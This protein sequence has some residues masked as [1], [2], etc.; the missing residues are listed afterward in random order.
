MSKYDEAQHPRNQDGRWRHKPAAAPAASLEDQA[1][2]RATKSRRSA[3]LK[4]GV[5]RTSLAQ[6][7]APETLEALSKSLT[8]VERREKALRRALVER[9]LQRAGALKAR[10]VANNDDDQLVIE[11]LQV[12][13]GVTVDKEAL[14]HTL[15]HVVDGIDGQV[16]TPPYLG[17]T[18]PW[19]GH[20]RV[21]VAAGDRVD[22]ARTAYDRAVQRLHASASA[23]TTALCLEAE[24]Q[25]AGHLDVQDDGVLIHETGQPLAVEGGHLAE[26][27]ATDGELGLP[28]HYVQDL[29][30]V[31]PSEDDS[32]W[33]V[34]VAEHLASQNVQVPGQTYLRV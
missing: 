14:Q 31:Y 22:E 13:A 2:T 5:V 24:R 6:L 20:D 27:V 26:L 32:S 19:R 12:R 8:S 7:S 4:T 29:P 17:I 21:T 10:L 15:N 18:D 33:S 11:D 34:D 3:R 23:A 9:E 1:P 25:G 28:R 30:G 16:D